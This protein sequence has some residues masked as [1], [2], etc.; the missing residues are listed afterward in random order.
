MPSSIPIFIPDSD[1]CWKGVIPEKVGPIC[2]ICL[3]FFGHVAYIIMFQDFPTALNIRSLMIQKKLTRGLFLLLI[4]GIA[5]CGGPKRIVLRGGTVHMPLLDGRVLR[6]QEQ[7]GGKT[8]DYTLHL[9][10]AGGRQVRAYQATFDGI[11]LGDCMFLSSGPKVTF[12]TTKPVTAMTAL[13]E[14]RQVWVDDTAQQGDEWYDGDMGTQT[15]F[16]GYETV[17][18]PAGTYENC[19]K[20]V[21]TVVPAFVDSLDKW[22]GRG[23]MSKEEHDE[24]AKDVNDVTVRWFASGAGLVKEQLNGPEHT[25]ELVAILEPGTGLAEPDTTQP[26]E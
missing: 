11:N 1:I 9:R 21:T 24:W 12:S 20:T 22:E 16:A 3:D 7:I 15:V 5:G 2:S 17:T 13:A 4:L 26:E 6:Y 10:Y 18:V 23:S 14:Y 19:Y 25:R 8:H